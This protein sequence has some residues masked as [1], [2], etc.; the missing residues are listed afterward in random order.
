M[1]PAYVRVKGESG[2][3][4]RG[5]LRHLQLRHERRSDFVPGPLHGDVGLR[6]I[7]YDDYRAAADRRYL[8]R[9]WPYY[10]EAIALA[11]R[12]GPRRVLEIGCRHTPLFPGSDRLDNAAEFNPTF[13][14]DATVVPWPV[15]DRSYDL[16]I[17]LQVW[18]HLGDRQREAFSELP[19]ISR[20]AILSLPFK[21]RRKN[22]PSHSGID[23]SV[24]KRWT[25]GLAPLE[26]VQLPLVGRRRRK[27]YLFDLSEAR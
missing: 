9:R 15:P 21:W 8:K 6:A 24:V 1:T 25:G 27:I 18:E 26:T 12:L 16:V 7:T 3:P 4:L 17:A 13:L 20:Y 14:H 5:L 19:R 10:R 2:G 11:E 23:D 22:N